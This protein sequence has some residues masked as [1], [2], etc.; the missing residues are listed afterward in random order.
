MRL[1]YACWYFVT[2][3]HNVQ[4]V[5]WHWLH[6]V[7]ILY[8]YYMYTYFKISVSMII[9][10]G[11]IRYVTSTFMYMH[12]M[13]LHIYNGWNCFQNCF[14]ANIAI[15]YWCS[16]AYCMAVVLCV[17]VWVL[18]KNQALAAAALNSDTQGSQDLLC[19]LEKVVSS[20]LAGLL[21]SCEAAKASKFW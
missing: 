11:T 1:C 20:W 6:A 4:A 18:A 3:G 2:H 10:V 16:C 21:L 12:N 5:N 7:Y 9:M 13:C 19:S 17:W 15:F 8:M 14:C